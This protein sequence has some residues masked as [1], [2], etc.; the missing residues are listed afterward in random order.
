[1]KKIDI[2]NN[3]QV[4]DQSKMIADEQTGFFGSEYE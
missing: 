4:Q 3:T 2:F 1:M